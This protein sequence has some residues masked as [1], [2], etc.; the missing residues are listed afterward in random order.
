VT[1]STAALPPGSA[2][3]DRLERIGDRFANAGDRVGEQEARRAAM[4]A[5]QAATA[6]EAARIEADFLKSQGLGSDGRP[7]KPVVGSHA[8]GGYVGY[9]RTVREG[10]SVAWRY[11]NPGY[12]RCS[13]KSAAYGAIGCDGEFAIFPDYQTG[14]NAL[15]LTLRDEHPGRPVGEALKQH[16]PPQAGSIEKVMSAA[17]LDPGKPTDSLTDGDFK[18]LGKGIQESAGWEAG[19]EID[20]SANDAP[21]WVSEAWEASASTADADEAKPPTDDS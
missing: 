12:I 10:G 20:R 2:V 14:L 8:G 17:K 21:D 9:G 16:L 11:N 1:V 13:P 7:A 3:A 18:D 15:R 19:N 5:R 4:R 6:A